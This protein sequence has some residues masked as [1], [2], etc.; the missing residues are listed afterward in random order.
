M[1][2]TRWEP[3]REVEE[4]LRQL[5]H[6]LAQL[7]FAREHRREDHSSGKQGRCV[8]RAHPEDAGNYAEAGLHR[9]QVIASGRRRALAPACDFHRR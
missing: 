2:I 6:V 1:S 9:S 8:V 7:L 3:F 4:M 5:W